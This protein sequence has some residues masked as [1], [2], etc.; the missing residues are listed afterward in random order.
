MSQNIYFVQCEC[1]FL[2]FLLCEHLTNANTCKQWT[3]LRHNKVRHKSSSVTV[4]ML[5]PQSLC[6]IVAKVFSLVF[7][8]DLT[9]AASKFQEVLTLLPDN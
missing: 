2:E 6:V 4:H 7:L 9:Q 5:H 8:L 3:W 1:V